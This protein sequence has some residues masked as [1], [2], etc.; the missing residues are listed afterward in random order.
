ML[1]TL[2]YE[3]YT[4]GWICALHVEALAARFMLDKRHDGVFPGRH[5]DD[6][7]YIAGS[8]GSHNVVLAGLPTKSIGTVSAAI[9][10]SQ[11]RQS[12]PNLRYGLMVGIGAGVPG[13]HLKPDVR[14]GDVVVAAPTEDSDDVQCVIGYELGKETAGGFIKKNWLY[15]TDLRLRT[16]I[17][18]IQ[19]ETE[20]NRSHGFLKHLDVF[21]TK[22]EGQ[23][24]LFPG[25]DN[26][27]L[28]EAEE[29]DDKYSLVARDPRDSQNPVVHYGRIG[30]GNKVIKNAKLRD[31]LR[32]KYNIICLE[33]EAAGLMNTLPVAVIR[34]ICD[35]A[36]CHKNDTW[37]HY[38]AATAASYA[39]ELLYA[40][41]ADP[42]ANPRLGGV[43]CADETKCLQS[44]Y[45]SDY[46]SHGKRNPDR[47]PGTCEWFLRHPK[48]RRWRQERQSSLL[49]VSGDPGCGKSVLV[50]FLLGE[51]KSDKSQAILP[52]TV[53]FFYFKDDNDKQNSA[54]SA[55]C[56]ILHQLFTTKKFLVKH[57]MPEYENKDQKFTNEFSTLWDIC[58]TGLNDADCGNVIC[59][60]DGVDECELLTRNLLIDSLIKFFSASGNRDTNSFLKFIVTSRPYG[61]I[62][63]Q[64]YS[65][66]TTAPPTIRLKMEDETTAISRDIELVVKA[67]V[68]EIGHIKSLPASARADLQ[69]H[70]RGERLGVPGSLNDIATTIPGTLHAVYD[71]ILRHVSNDEASRKLLHIIVAAMR[72]LSLEEMNVALNITRCDHSNEDLDL[73]PSIHSTIKELCGPLV[74]IVNS[75]VYLVHHTAKE[76]LTRSNGEIDMSL[77]PWKHS[78]YQNESNLIL[79][80]ACT[81]YLLFSHFQDHPLEINFRLPSLDIESQVDQYARRHN[82]LDY[83]AKNWATHFQQTGIQG[84]S[85]LKKT[86]LD[87]CDSQS[88]RFRTWFWVYQSN[89]DVYFPPHTCPMDP[90]I[91]SSFR[92]EVIKRSLQPKK[93]FKSPWIALHWAARSGYSAVVQVLLENGASAASKTHSGWTALSW[94]ASTGHRDIVELLLNK[95]ADVRTKTAFGWTP[96]HL[97]VGNGHIS[98]VQLLL[99]N[100]SEIDAKDPDGCTASHRALVIGRYDIV[101][102][103]VQH[104]TDINVE[105]MGRN[106]LLHS[107]A[108]SGQEEVVRL[109]LRNG[110]NIASKAENGETALHRAAGNGH[111][112]VVRLLLEEGALVNAKDVYGGTSLHWAFDSENGA[113]I[114]LLLKQGADTNATTIHGGT[115]LHRA[116]WNGNVTAVRMLIEN[117]FDIY[118]ENRIGE[119]AAMLAV[120]P[121]YE[122]I[123]R[124]L[125]KQPTRDL[126]DDMIAMNAAGLPHLQWAARRGHEAITELLLMKGVDGNERD[127]IGLITL[128][129]AISSG[130]KK[131]VLIL[132]EKGTDVN[133][134]YLTGRTALHEA[135]LTGN[136]EIV[137]LLLE[138]GADINATCQGGWTALHEAVLTGNKEIVSLLL[139]KG[140]DINATCQGGWTA[141][142]EAVL[143]GNKEIV[144]LLL[145]KGADINATY[146]GRW[147]ALHEAVSTGNREIVSLLLEK[148]PRNDIVYLTG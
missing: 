130:N 129:H 101:R 117:G 23:K 98:V 147:R 120:M 8:I 34:G 141:L 139:E 62:E 127:F 3:D 137:S 50:S 32:D 66:R 33:M 87:V 90:M 138:K 122:D 53:C 112:T 10:V 38:A 104:G 80:E 71:K 125:L 88:Q 4:I 103:L 86:I 37:R 132:L 123:V 69:K 93:A 26:D 72:P 54:T 145:E 111:D 94:A 1:A 68:D 49:W 96:L 61:A 44:L 97:A 79:T 21:Q 119:T 126:G 91:R 7:N 140:A 20:F 59:V 19:T 13:R 30:S 105:D 41:G 83:A 85:L 114:R 25:V 65:P 17:S 60:L 45:K 46:K 14:L 143:T 12:F 35:Y 106:T 99:E 110:A 9:L 42:L 92:V 73:E 116:A 82:F 28:Y 63:R 133:T 2:R 142:H 27:Q 84:N 31:E 113:L 39:K 78:L 40:I 118:D 77:G 134:R 56:A 109:L 135:V 47:V 115:V 58:T 81:W 55:L 43:L 74:K 148:E 5:G 136:R 15:P 16:A 64:F 36:D 29:A 131:M 75:K 100:G 22:P 102:L 70:G 18:T 107:A 6:N 51:L 144:S 11:M 52:G 121:G 57:A 95:G 128:H 67:K 89:T 146:Q 76:F 48:Y 108:A 124:L 24:F